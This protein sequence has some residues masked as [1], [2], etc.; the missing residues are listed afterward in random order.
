MAVFEVSVFESS[1]DF[2]A[3]KLESMKEAHQGFVSMSALLGTIL[4]AS[5]T[6]NDMMTDHSLG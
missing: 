3:L 5:V 2:L 4:E 6:Q 1:E